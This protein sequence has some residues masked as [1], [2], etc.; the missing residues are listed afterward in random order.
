MLLLFSCDKSISS[1]EINACSGTS[2]WCLDDDGILDNYNDYQ[3]NGSIT[4]IVTAN[5][6]SIGQDGDILG[7]FVGDELRGVASAIEVPPE[8]GEGYTFL[9]LAYSNQAVGES[10]DF[11][12]YDYDLNLIYDIVESVNFISDMT[13]GNIILPVSLEIVN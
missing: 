12:F 4:S 6:I 13:E 10:L 1:A 7:A 3:F 2:A 8:L 5:N 11:K 9:L